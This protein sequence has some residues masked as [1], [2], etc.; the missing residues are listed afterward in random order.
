MNVC[1]GSSVR[2][3]FGALRETPSSDFDYDC[4]FFDV[5]NLEWTTSSASPV[6]VVKRSKKGI[7]GSASSTSL[8]TKHVSQGG[9]C[10]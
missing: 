1:S 6:S 7:P 8:S 2:A 4:F 9:C 10:L 5:L 3:D